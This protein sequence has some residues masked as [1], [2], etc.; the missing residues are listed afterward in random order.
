MYP[1][2]RLGLELARA[3]GAAPLPLDG[4]HVSQH[5]VWPWDLDPWVELNNGRTLSL[6]DLGRV[7]MARRNG[8]TAALRRQ[9]WRFT[10]AGSTLR[11]RRRVQVL[12]RLEMRSRLIG[13]DARFF[14]M[15]QAMYRPREAASEATSSVLIRA[16]VIDAGGIVATDRVMA[17]LG[18][19]DWRPE[20]PAWVT[21]WT[22]AEA[23]RP[24][25]P[26]I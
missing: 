23:A 17:A 24:W 13:R 6:Y 11:Y 7:P 10:V 14:Y 9:G 26:E 21:A 19:P 22:L 16:A 20:L 2:L 15:H 18:A 1:F 8:F 3:R 4:M 5:R 25:P 12:E